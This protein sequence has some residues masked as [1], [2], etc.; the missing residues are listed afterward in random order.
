[1]LRSMYSGV[2]G[3]R[4]HQLYMDTVGN[5]IANVNTTGYKSSG[6]IF[7]DMMSQILSG[8]GAPTELSGGT[9]PAQVGLGTRIAGIQTSFLQGAA[10]LTGRATDMAIQG[11]GFFITR[12]GNDTLYTRAGALSFDA[13]GSLVTPNGGVIQGW[14]AD[15]NGELD[16]NSPVTDLA[17][18]IGQ[19]LQ[20]NETSV[21]SLGGNLPANAEVGDTIVS[22]IDVV[23][24]Q[25]A[26]LS[27]TMSWAKTADDTWDLTATTP[28]PANPGS[29]ID[30]ISPA[31]QVTFDP[32][33]GL[34]SSASVTFPTSGLPGQWTGTD[35]TLD[36]GEPGDPDGLVQ[37][38]GEQTMT[39]LSQDGSEIGFLS[40]FSI[41]PSGMISGVFSNGLRRQ[42]GQVALANFNNAS[43]LERAGDTAFRATANSGEAALGVAGTGQLG[44]IAGGTVEMSNVD[45]AAEFTNMIAAQRGFQANSRVITASDEIL[46]DLVNMKR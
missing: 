4:S 28:D 1:M 31:Q 7:S 8:A 13:N 17:L 18:P 3:L 24:A 22:T 35:I 34:P 21:V 16:I 43:G 12:T 25:G 39:A 11:E 23:D 26:P 27:I 2:S 42:L 37:F 33:T 14:A 30:L 29:E 20:P 5:N 45:L 10:Q 15:A 36:L 6:V 46:Q 19:I 38:A 40:S 32:A 44:S 9:N 41:D